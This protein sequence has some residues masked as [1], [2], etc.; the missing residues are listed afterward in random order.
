MMSATV[1]SL[2]LPAA[3]IIDKTSC[4]T[5]TN[6]YGFRLATSFVVENVNLIFVRVYMV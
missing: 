5:P 6:V 2:T 3:Q 1:L 4:P